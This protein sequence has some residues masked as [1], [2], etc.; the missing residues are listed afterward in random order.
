[1]MNGVLALLCLS[2]AFSQAALAL[3]GEPTLKF[4]AVGTLS[5][6]FCKAT[7]VNR[8]AGVTAAH[9]AIGPGVAKGFYSGPIFDSIFLLNQKS[10][11]QKYS[12]VSYRSLGKSLG[13]N[14][15]A[16]FVL[17]RP[18]PKGEIQPLP[19]RSKRFNKNQKVILVGGACPDPQRPAQFLRF[20]Y[21]YLE[22]RMYVSPKGYGDRFVN[23]I[24]LGDSGGV[25]IDPTVGQVGAVISSF[26]CHK[27]M[28]KK[29]GVIVSCDTQTVNFV[30]MHMHY[31]KVQSLLSQEEPLLKRRL[32]LYKEKQKFTNEAQ[33][34]FEQHG[35][36]L[37]RAPFKVHRRIP[38]FASPENTGDTEIF[39]SR[40]NDQLKVRG[41]II[42]KGS[43]YYFI[44]LTPS[45]TSRKR[46]RGLFGEDDLV[47][48][49][50]VKARDVERE[51]PVQH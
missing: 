42:F 24:C 9:C 50:W 31:K 21:Q 11:S 44:S 27:N 33:Q 14:D 6:S 16:L 5:R 48:W 39:W 10:E 22:K 12:I 47:W 28:K 13:A 26:T 15:L 2:L 49:G 8:W 32:A 25:L 19:L 1:M 7:M 37:E 23:R 18:I 20:E 41:Y 4:G 43:R 30:N 46:F 45:K 17:A 3:V 51:L 35:V 38:I 29:N 36:K 34:W 40:N